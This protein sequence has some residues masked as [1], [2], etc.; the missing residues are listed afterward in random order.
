MLYRNPPE[1]HEEFI[2]R[3]DLSK[4]EVTEKMK[5][6][7]ADQRELLCRGTTSNQLP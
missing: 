6:M 1:T 3:R 5:N 4:A 2:A 7:T